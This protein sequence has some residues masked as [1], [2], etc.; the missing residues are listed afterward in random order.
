MNAQKES[1][2][3]AMNEQ[4]SEV[5]TFNFSESKNEI[6]NLLLDN[7]VW[8]IAKD[9]CD[10]LG[11]INNRQAIRELDDDEKLTYKLYTSGQNRNTS[12]ISE[13]G[14]YALILRSNKPY[15]K[16]FRKWITSEVIPTILKKGFYTINSSK[17]KTDFIDARNIPYG[18]VVVNETPVRMI[19]VD[20][21]EYYSINDYHNAINSRTGANQAAK[22]LNALESL[23]VK[24]WLF[25][26]THPAWFTKIR[27]LELLGSGSRIMKSSNQLI[28][29]L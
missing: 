10:A 13:S 4:T 23:A 18:K 1:G 14:L 15:A 24:I 3:Q 19:V 17:N 20:E 21:V 26:N 5:M 9:V 12:I 6:R 27:G 28:L 22:K 29:P 16:T 25:G 2:A 11:I 7:K 8:F